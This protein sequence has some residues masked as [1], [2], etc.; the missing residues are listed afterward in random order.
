MT[1]LEFI[2]EIKQNIANFDNNL[3]VLS[4]VDSKCDT[5]ADWHRMFTKWCEVGTEMEKE[6]YPYPPTERKPASTQTL[7][8]GKY[9]DVVFVQWDSCY[10]PSGE[11]D[12]LSFSMY[13]NP[14]HYEIHV[15]KPNKQ[16]SG[17]GVV[18]YDHVETL[19]IP[20]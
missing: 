17:G 19:L 8:L 1:R 2:A 6:Y 10:I 14:T 9:G 15:S 13:W 7:N 11:K 20:K 3:G 18:F 5:Y 12:G 4:D 16:Q